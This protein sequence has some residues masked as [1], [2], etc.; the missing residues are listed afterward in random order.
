[1]NMILHGVNYQKFDI[2]Q[3]DS[4][5]RPMHLELRAEAIVANPPFSAHWS[6][7]P[8]HLGDDRFSQFGRLAPSSKADWAF[9]QHMIHHLHENG[10]MTVVAPHGVLFRGA[11]EGHLRRY[12]IEDRNYLDAVIGLPANIFYGTSIPTCVL[13]F[14]RCKE[15]FDNILF[16]DASQGF[17]KRGNQN[18]LRAEDIDRIISTYR[19]R[20]V[21]DKYSNVATLYEVKEND[22]NLNIPRYVD[23]FKEEK[24]VDLEAITEELNSMSFGPK[25][26]ARL[27]NGYARRKGLKPTISSRSLRTIYSPS[28]S[29][30]LM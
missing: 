4:L 11:A 22:Y 30:C 19:E 3:E 20:T 10:T 27:S 1:M 12:L 17:E 5:E 13:V 16:V 8:L 25:N 23:T 29:R 6:A 2:K 7:N 28:K 14:K 9:I 21:H 26:S 18:Y 24:Q 15:H